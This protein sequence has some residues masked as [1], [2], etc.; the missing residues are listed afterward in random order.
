MFQNISG[1]GNPRVQIFHAGRLKI[2]LWNLA[3]II[4]GDA[5]DHH[6]PCGFVLQAGKFQQSA[7]EK[8]RFHDK[9]LVLDFFKR[10][11]D[12]EID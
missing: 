10:T 12:F 9:N 8:I 7:E 6:Q 3:Q 5:A 1:F 2:I 4:C 11:A